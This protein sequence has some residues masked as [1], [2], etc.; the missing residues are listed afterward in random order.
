[1]PNSVKLKEI[2][3]KHWNHT[4]FRPLQE[5][6]IT[7]IISGNDTLAILP[8]GGGKSICY[9]IPAL[10]MEGTCVVI[11]PLTALIKDQI[12]QLKQKGIEAI[13]IPSNSSIDDI[14]RLFDN[15]KIK[16][17]KLLY[18]SP[19]RLSQPIL[20]EKLQQLNIS[21]IAVDEA[22][23][24]SQ[25]GHD[26]RPSYIK[27][28][29]IRNML[30]KIP[31]LAVT[32]TAT[33]KT[34]EQIIS[35]LQLKKPKF[36]IGSF[37]RE[38]LAYQLFETPQK[39]D[40]LTKILSKRKV[41]AIVYLQNRLAVKELSDRL[42]SI[43]LPTTYYHAGL[44]TAEK[45]KSFN[46]WNS[47]EKHIMI[48]TNA[49]GMGI[50]KSNVRLVIHL[51]IPSTLEN[52]LQEA[53]RA[54]RDGQK[55]FS[56]VILS[57]NDFKK[58][59]HQIQ[60]NITFQHVYDVYLK[61][62]QHF[63]IAYGDHNEEELDFDLQGFCQRYQLNINNT[64]KALRRL[65][66]YQILNYKEQHKS[67]THIKIT[68]SHY[69]LMHFCNEHTSYKELIDTVLRNYSGL[70]E[71][72]K[73]LNI[74][75]LASKTGLSIHLIH[76]KLSYLQQLN[77]I[78]LKLKQNNHTL[79]FLVPREDK[80]TLNPVEK[81]I[82]ALH[83]IE[84]IKH[85]S[86]ISYFKNQEE[87]RNNIILNYFN[88]PYVKD[89]GICDICIQKNNPVSTSVLNNQIATLLKTKPCTFNELLTNIKVNSQVLKY[90]LT[91]LINENKIIQNQ[92]F[93]QLT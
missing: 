57:E 66:N 4:S 65:D 77:F 47:E 69:Q 31:F 92:Q 71:V 9:Q 53:G 22:H 75:R 52:Y 93:Y 59:D 87:C 3:Q 51:E 49:F 26:F 67:D 83:T 34:Q 27:V 29:L 35:L 30:S 70:F 60:S 84:L 72:S 5:S 73:K 64:E 37:S 56:C 63:Q 33:K 14:V 55:S 15:I 18:L 91:E 89:C 40:L 43:G 36:H 62:N 41:T 68:C 10:Y 44:S 50:D 48:A 86:S 12:Y 7:D 19:E 39:F 78:D 46:A 58:F 2:L 21:F 1:M 8:T 74:P 25:W 81:D 42:N 32:A 11:S 54:G 80:N 45:D 82:T 20:Q 88:Q 85:K 17:I 6:I 61:L 76:K 16:K 23:C 28:G 13:S 24:I 38:N 90:L 79:T